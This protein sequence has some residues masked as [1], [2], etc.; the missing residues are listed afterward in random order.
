MHHTQDLQTETLDTDVTELTKIYVWRML[1]QTVTAPH[2]II[3]S[4]TM[5]L[6]VSQ[7]TVKVKQSL[8]RPG[9]TLRV[10]TR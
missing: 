5:A 6:T 2:E 10:P 9:Q 7:V 1:F 3:T 8:Y 4:A